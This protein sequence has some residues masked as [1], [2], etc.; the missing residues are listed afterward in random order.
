MIALGLA[1][2]MVPIGGGWRTGPP[3]AD[4][5]QS[6]HQRPLFGPRAKLQANSKAYRNAREALPPGFMDYQTRRFIVISDADPRWSRTQG[7]R[8]ERTYH[9]FH[10]Y[11]KRL[12]VKPTALR[13]KLVCV[14]FSHRDSYRAFASEHDDVTA[15]WIS[16]Y[17]SP[18]N[19]RI[20]FYNLESENAFADASLDVGRDHWAWPEVRRSRERFMSDR[21]KAATATTVH[22]AVHQLAFHTGMQSAHIQ[23]P[24]WISEGLATSFE[25]DTP[26][27]AFGPEYDYW[28]RRE[29][30]LRLLESE[31]LISLRE[32]V[33]YSEMPDDRDQTI[34]AVYHQSYALVG[35]LSRFRRA[36][37]R[38]FL[39][40]LLKEPPGRP[41]AVR[42][43]QIFEE[44]FGDIEL[45][46]SR[47]L[48]FERKALD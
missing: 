31:V 10:R 11:A 39:N 44:H 21:S 28:M 5:G 2:V 24:L 8:L 38:D 47:W 18:L 29:E 4:L 36:E 14:L 48:A 40:A 41:T 16:G 19:D 17:Y 23:N 42:Q 12:G 35:W 32:L 43:V 46:E 9:Q 45:L 7:E 27:Q 37:L 22:E 33:S 15:D 34:T 30:F 6:N 20:V 1:V 3:V 26:N 25:T 13:H